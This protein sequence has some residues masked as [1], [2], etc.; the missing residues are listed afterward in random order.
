MQEEEIFVWFGDAS[1]DM[2]T[3]TLHNIRFNYV[4]DVVQFDYFISPAETCS[5]GNVNVYYGAE[6]VI[7]SSD[8]LD[9]DCGLRSDGCLGITQITFCQDATPSVFTSLPSSEPAALMPVLDTPTSVISSPAP[10]IGVPTAAPSDLPFPVIIKGVPTA[11][12]TVRDNPTAVIT[13]PAPTIGVPTASPSDLPFP[14]IIKGVPTAYP[15]VRV[16]SN[17][18]I[19]TNSSNLPTSSTSSI[20]SNTCYQSCGSPNSAWSDAIS[21]VGFEPCVNGLSI[22]SSRLPVYDMVSLLLITLIISD[23]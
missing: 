13:S 21:S 8:S 10:T 12:P 22:G 2:C 11:Y 18:P 5:V 16:P 4:G 9:S 23:T 3:L 15:T 20:P 14:V 17:R 6:H 19:T 7:Y 1:G